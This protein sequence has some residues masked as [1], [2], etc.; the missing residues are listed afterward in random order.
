MVFHWHCPYLS[1]FQDS[2]VVVEV[3][4]AIV[5]AIVEAIEE[6][7]RVTEGIIIIV[8]E[9]VSRVQLVL[10]CPQTSRAEGHL[11]TNYIS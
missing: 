4:E 2:V 11:I 8:M 3:I 6:D 10:K 5:E 9:D 1:F 7:H